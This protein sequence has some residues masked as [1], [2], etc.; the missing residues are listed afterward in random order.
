MF[1]STQHEEARHKE[2]LALTSLQRDASNL[3]E[4]DQ[5]LAEMSSDSDDDIFDPE[6]ELDDSYLNNIRESKRGELSVGKAGGKSKASARK[7]STKAGGVGGSKGKL[8]STSDNRSTSTVP[9]TATGDKVEKKEP[10]ERKIYTRGGSNLYEGLDTAFE[11]TVPKNDLFDEVMTPV[12][13]GAAG[14]R[15]GRRAQV[16]RLSSN[17]RVVLDH[18]VKFR[19]LLQDKEAGVEAKCSRLYT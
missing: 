7:N 11:N 18:G 16:V 3:S 5:S 12:S 13:G 17:D 4:A 9:V 10:S 6:C 15:G 1:L 19:D 8:N 2:G 14:G